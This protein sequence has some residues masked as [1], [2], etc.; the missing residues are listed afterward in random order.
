MWLVAEK[1]TP[2]RL[3]LLKI[4]CSVHHFYPTC[5]IRNIKALKLALG[6]EWRTETHSE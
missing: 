2:P 4:L 1:N 3:L 6:Q 5:S